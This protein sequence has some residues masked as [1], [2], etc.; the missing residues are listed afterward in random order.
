MGMSSDKSVEGVVEQ[1]AGLPLSAT[2]TMSRHPRALDPVA[3]AKRI[4]PFCSDVHVMPD[5]V[6]AYTYLVNAV[7]PEDVVV[8]MG[9]FFLVGELRSVLRRSQMAQPRARALAAA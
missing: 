4:S 7:S 5:P 6:D 1:L 9:S 8:V 2:C 3:L